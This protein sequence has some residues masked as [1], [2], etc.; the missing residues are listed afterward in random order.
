[1]VQAISARFP[2]APGGN[3]VLY[4]PAPLEKYFPVAPGIEVS[5]ESIEEYDSGNGRHLLFYDRRGR[6]INRPEKGVLVDTVVG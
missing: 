3:L 1:M 2:F 4:Q 5:V 6:M